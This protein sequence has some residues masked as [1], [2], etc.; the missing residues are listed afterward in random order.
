MRG[1]V[2]EGLRLPLLVF[3]LV[4]VDPFTLLSCG[5]RSSGDDRSRRGARPRLRAPRS[6]SNLEAASGG[7]LLDLR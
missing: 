5:M 1:R 4:I 6:A 2:E 3:A 7:L